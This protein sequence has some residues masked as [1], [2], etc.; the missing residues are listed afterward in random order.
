MAKVKITVVKKLDANDLFG[1]NIPIKIKPGSLK[2]VCTE[3]NEGQEFIVDFVCPPGFCGVAFS[4]MQKEIEH[5]IFGG[6]YSWYEEKGAT[7]SCC[8][9]GLR[10]VIF[11]LEKVA[12]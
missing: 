7:L 1:D 8:S 4:D 3:F 10:P 6:S 2:P 11:K 9:D 5:I 12:D